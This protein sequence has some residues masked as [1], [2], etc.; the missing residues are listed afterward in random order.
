MK[1]SIQLKRNRQKKKPG[2]KITKWRKNCGRR[3]TDLMGLR[4]AIYDYEERGTQEKAD[5]VKYLT[6]VCEKKHGADATKKTISA[7][8]CVLHKR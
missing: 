8:F 2:E 7:A 3:S 4:E 6:G 5:I 1:T